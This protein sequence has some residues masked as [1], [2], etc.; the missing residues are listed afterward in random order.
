M[1][2]ANMRVLTRNSSNSRLTP[3]KYLYKMCVCCTGARCSVELFQN[4][5][6]FGASM[7]GVP[8]VDCRT[9]DN[10]MFNRPQFIP[11]SQQQQHRLYY[12]LL[13]V[14]ICIHSYM[15]CAIG[16]SLPLKTFLHG[17]YVS[18]IRIHSVIICTARITYVCD[19]IRSFARCSDGVFRHNMPLLRTIDVF[20][21][22]R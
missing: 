5:P 8:Y 22:S 21:D 9:Y 13:Y 15:S 4:M 11:A 1:Q 14:H 3:L 10:T 12:S 7:Y 18:E 2:L 16:P 20:A 19:G 6:L 17:S